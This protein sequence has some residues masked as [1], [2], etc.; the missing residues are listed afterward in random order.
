MLARSRLDAAR[1]VDVKCMMNESGGD[2]SKE[3]SKINT[4][5]DTV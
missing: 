2:C 4:A 3:E 5:L 1:A